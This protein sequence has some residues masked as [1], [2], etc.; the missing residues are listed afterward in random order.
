MGLTHLVRQALRLS[1]RAVAVQ[2]GR[3]LR[4]LVGGRLAQARWSRTCTYAD[5]TGGLG[6]DFIPALPSAVLEPLAALLRAEAG[7]LLAHR[8]DLLGSGEVEIGHGMTC[9]GFLG[10]RFPAVPPPA[11]GDLASSLSPGNRGRSQAIRALIG[12]GYRPIDW[13][14]DF[15]SGHRWSE[16]VWHAAQPYGHLPGVDVKVPWE[17][18]RLQH[19]PRLALAFALDPDDSRL[20]D[21]YRAQVLDFL[22]AN[23]PGFGI[24]W[25]CPMDVAIRGANLVLAHGLFVRHGARFDSTF[26]AELGA[27]LVAHG[28]H[29]RANLEWHPTRRGNHYLADLAGLTW[30]ARAL[31]E[32]PEAR[33]WLVL[34]TRELAAEIPRQLGPDG[35]G[36]EASTGYHRLVA[37]MAAWCLALDPA[38]FPAPCAERLMRA[39]EFSLHVTKPDGRAAQVGDTDN[40]RFFALLPQEEALDHRTSVAAIN[41]LFGRE[42]L[43]AFAGPQAGVAGALVFALAGGRRL[44]GGPGL[45]AMARRV[46]AQGVECTPVETVIHLP[47]PRLLEGLE[48]AAYPDFGIY[49]WRGPRFFLAVRCGG[50][51]ADGSGGHAHND[52]LALELQVDG[53]DWLADPGSFVYTADSGLRNA[54]RSVLAHAAPRRGRDE[55]SP[56]DLG[57]FRLED[58][59]RATCLRFD[60]AG[61]LGIHH[62][63]G[64]P[65]QRSIRLDAARGLVIVGDSGPE[66]RTCELRSKAA[67][68]A[69]FGPFPPF[70]PGYGRRD[71]K[72]S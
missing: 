27:G 6:V 45:A 30:I 38:A 63:F 8:F 16:A 62:G 25:A 19:L 55:P 5:A 22:A 52:Q 41:G 20:R 42:D 68:R 17:L 28:R 35:G 56:L 44:D 32:V 10:I 70:S 67:V 34:A 60:A 37:E 13:Q 21:E 71:G 58:R 3:Y 23:P 40:G 39:A 48:A 9:P 61:F 51:G 11:E 54:Y 47:D 14:I 64:P 7:R 24:Q 36:F 57:L 1:P 49:L 72:K 29:V 33:D 12:V 53:E 69:H 26:L 59:C 15:R 2:G 18:G 43:A 66:R 46:G 4:R 65:V 31:P 50:F